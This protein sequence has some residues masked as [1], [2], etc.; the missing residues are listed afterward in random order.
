MQ[1]L[2]LTGGAG[3]IGSALAGMLASTQRFEVVILDKL[4]YAG[5]YAN[6]ESL[7]GE[8]CHFVH[9]DICDAALVERLFLAHRFDYVINCA[10]ESHVDRSIASSDV[11]IQ[12]N[13]CGVQ[14]LLDACVRHGVRKF[15]QMSTDE[16]YGELGETGLFTEAS[17]I[18]P[19]SP[20]SASKASADLLVLSWHRTYGLPVNITRS[21]NNYGPRQHPEKLIP[22]M[23]QCALAE[24]ALPVYGDGSNVR[25]W[26][27]VDDHCA[28]VLMVLEHGESGRVYN[29]GS[30]CEYSNLTIVQ[31]ICEHLNRPTSLIELVSDRK[32]HDWR[33]A[34]DYSRIH[35]EL[36]WSPV[37]PFQDGLSQTI[38][39]Y[40]AHPDWFESRN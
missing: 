26:I 13:V 23:I 16:V 9:G 7:L 21:S 39:W 10:A 15:Q 18:C 35:S 12:T 17:P 6:I 19:S 37:T 36:G 27:H 32:G 22:K 4:T 29:I 28:A 2:L 31:Q 1:S 33:Y 40:L 5:R 30:D 8:R 11:F 25:E 34:V 3:F 20:Y 24:V 38:Q 14:V